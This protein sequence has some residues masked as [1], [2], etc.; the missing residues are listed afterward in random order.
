MFEMRTLDGLVPKTVFDTC[1][2]LLLQ[3][4]LKA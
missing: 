1:T 4:G 3:H 2:D